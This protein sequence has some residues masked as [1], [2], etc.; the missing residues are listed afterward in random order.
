[1]TPCLPE[2]RAWVTVAAW[3]ESV[4]EKRAAVLHEDLV[5]RVVVVVLVGLVLDSHDARTIVVNLFCSKK[6]FVYL[7]C[8]IWDN[9][10]EFNI[11]KWSL[12]LY[13][14]FSLLTKFCLIY[15]LYLLR[16]Q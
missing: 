13:F 15:R 5:H 1:M 2:W 11:S 3:S 8:H 16:F 7:T 4:D 14:I 12:Y 6:I 10:F 9:T